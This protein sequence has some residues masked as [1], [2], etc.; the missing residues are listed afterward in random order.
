[1]QPR[2]HAYAL[3]ALL[4]VSFLLSSSSM[5]RKAR[6]FDQID[7]L[8]DIRHEIV[9]EYV[10]EPDQ[11]KMAELAVKGMVDSL[12]DPYTIYLPPQE[13]GGFEKQVRGTF[14]GIGAE[15]DTHE[16]HL[17]IVTPLEGSP[18]WKEST[19]CS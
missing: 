2:F 1:M 12:N 8:V 5:A 17:R 14:S 18:A 11:K 13:L 19:E 4:I 10:E 9:S 3:T 6:V 7:L 16:N 15:V